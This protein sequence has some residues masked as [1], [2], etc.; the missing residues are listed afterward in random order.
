MLQ[1]IQAFVII[2]SAAIAPT[3]SSSVAKDA[4]AATPLRNHRDLEALVYYCNDGDTCR[5]GIGEAL[6]FNVR[7]AG[8]DAP[9]TGR[10]GGQPL[11]DEAR[12]A[13]NRLIKG[14]LVLLRQTD[15]DQYNRPVVEI[16]LQNNLVNVAQIEGGWAEMYRG[17][18]K[19]LDRTIYEQAEAKARA[20]KRGIW[21][22]AE[23][24][25]PAAFRKDK[26]SKTR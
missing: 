7:L 9:E 26:R 14:K 19:R 8:I 1:A 22:L 2:A 21:G 10:K 4:G 12:D 15:L 5:V 6:W 13:L 25:S 20:T 23:Y 11:G 24:Q 16:L 18:T 3:P 17:K